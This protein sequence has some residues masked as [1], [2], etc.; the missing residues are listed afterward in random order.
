MSE[1]II[2]R[3][4][5]GPPASANGGYACGLLALFIDGPAEVTLRLPPPLDTALAVERADGRTVL[6]H[7]EALIA[8]AVA[9]TVDI[10]PPPSPGLELAR[11][12]SARSQS[13]EKHI[14]PGCFVCGPEREAGDGLRI[15]PGPG[16]AE[17]LVAA[18]WTPD[19]SLT[20]D[21]TTVRPEL[22]WAV[23]DCPGGFSFLDFEA[24]VD[25]GYLLG[26]LAARVERPVVVGRA[27]VVI[28][29]PLERDGRKQYAGAALYE[30]DG[31]LCA[32]ARQTWIALTK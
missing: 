14:Y 2:D 7:G 12:A 25:N 27:Y 32:V 11:D 22:I 30:E 24:G 20:D 17:G 15:F 16:G 9:A 3:R 6:R 5:R 8:E 19:A 18:P 4:F 26:R 1:L 21:G 23:I 10:V 28:G 29:W 13:L 31:A